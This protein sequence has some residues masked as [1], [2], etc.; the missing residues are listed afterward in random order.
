MGGGCAFFD[1]DGDGDQD[2]LLIN[3]TTWTEDGEE[4][5]GGATTH[6]YRNDG[7]GHFDDVSRAVGLDVRLFGTGVAVGDYDRDGDIDVFISAVG[8]NRLYENRGGVF[9]DVTRKA[10]VGGAADR[11]STSCGFFDYDTDGDLDL[12]VCNY[13]SWSREIDLEVNFQ[14]T[15]I[16]RAYGPPTNFAGTH[17]YLYRNAGD[18]TFEDASQ[19]AG[20]QVDNPSTGKAMGKALGVVFYDS[21]DDGRI[22]ILV[23]NDT[24]QNFF[25]RN[26]GDGTF[27]EHGGEAG[28]AF[29]SN[30]LSTGAMGVDVAHFRNDASLGVGVGNFSNEMS[31]LYVTQGE[32]S[33]LLYSDEAI[34]EGIG[35]A[36]RLMLSFG[37]FFFD[38]DL[39]GRL[40][41]FQTNG[42]LEE[43]INI[44]QPSQ[45]YK[46]PAQLFWNA[47]SEARQGFTP[48]DSA[49]AGDLAQA[50]VGRA[51]A[52]ADIDG[53]GDLDIVVTQVGERPVLLRNE[54]DLG[55]RWLR[56]RLVGRTANRDGIGAWVEPPCS[57]R[58]LT[59]P[60]SPRKSV[61]DQ[62]YRYTG[63]RTSMR[64]SRR[65]TAPSLG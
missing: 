23:A 31:S 21:D 46:Q 60:G 58:S 34:A 40:D 4:P 51:A 24:V 15:G 32:R 33:L 61:L 47:G 16:G 17:S 30:G 65:Q 54:Q 48:V 10:G 14:L 11:W 37:L 5:S 59:M 44:V 6:L 49:T 36:S 18:G 50:I 57:P 26:R 20:I 3:S 8:E 27:E 38:Y 55:H 1:Y 56:V 35:P 64:P 9:H 52:Y 7:R 39:D 2:L 19:A 12:F 62:P 28:I 45:N 29:D 22:D 43:E 42:H 13:V 25:F 63:S 53:D 41:L